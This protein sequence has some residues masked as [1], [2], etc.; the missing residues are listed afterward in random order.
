VEEDVSLAFYFT[1]ILA[2]VTWSAAVQILGYPPFLA[3][4]GWAVAVL[5]VGTYDIWSNRE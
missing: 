2:A 1:V 3:V 5:V 4:C